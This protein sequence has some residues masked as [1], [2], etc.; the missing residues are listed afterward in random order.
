M[1]RN[2]VLFPLSSLVLGLSMM[3]CGASIDEG[4]SEPQ[5]ARLNSEE[6]E[7]NTERAHPTSEVVDES[8]E[9]ASELAN[10]QESVS[11]TEGEEVFQDLADDQ[12]AMEAAERLMG[13]TMQE[14]GVSRLV[15]VGI[16]EAAE[17]VE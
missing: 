6:V 1:P 8:R 2:R 3:G 13:V 7:V 14:P 12:I 9:M 4:P 15:S 16:D 17:L 10:L 11:V 5:R